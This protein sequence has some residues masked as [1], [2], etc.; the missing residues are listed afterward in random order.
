[1]EDHVVLNN[2]VRKRLNPVVLYGLL[3]IFLVAGCAHPQSGHLM[4]PQKYQMRLASAAGQD[5]MPLYFAEMSQKDFGNSE[6][7]QFDEEFL[8]EKERIPDPLESWNRVMFHFNDRLY[9]LLLKPISIGYKA[10]FPQPV[11]V[12]VRNFFENLEFPIRFINCLLQAK[13][14]GAATELTRFA[15]NSTVGMGGFLDVAEEN[16]GLR[17][18]EEDFGQTLG[19]YG[20]G[21]GIY[22]NW[23]ILQACSLTGT[24]GLVG[25][26]F[27]DPSNYLSDIRYVLAVQSYEGINYIS[28]TIGGYEDLK[29]A[30]ID[31]Y[32]A[33]RDAYCQYRRKMIEE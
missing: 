17:E 7:D 28:L 2:E 8:E 33:A 5:P 32:I 20:L 23:P 14:E 25:D 10:I 6:F 1:M 29:R 30:A 9:F 16:L 26:A 11:R 24:I 12:G 19:F 3:S 4:P 31:P 15:V 21:P 22:I 18:Q 27:L 13:F